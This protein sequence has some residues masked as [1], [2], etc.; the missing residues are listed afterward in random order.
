MGPGRASFSGGSKP[1]RDSSARTVL[2]ASPTMDPFTWGTSSSS[3]GIVSGPTINPA[4]DSSART[5]LKPSPTIG[6]YKRGTSASSADIVSNPTINPSRDSSARTVLKASPTV[7]SYTWG[8]SSSSGGIASSPTINNH[9]RTDSIYEWPDIE[10]TE[11]DDASADIIWTWPALDSHAPVHKGA[12]KAKKRSAAEM[13]AD[14]GTST[15][16]PPPQ[17]R[18]R[19]KVDPR[20]QLPRDSPSGIPRSDSRVLD[21]LEKAPIEIVDAPSPKRKTRPS[22]TS[23]R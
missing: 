9:F 10:P 11:F 20:G 4:R 13:E 8:A 15:E 12:A 1:S 19:T 3:G 6:P 23:K 18:K 5:V 17:I 2:K 21:G 14:A 7:G 22:R 16:P